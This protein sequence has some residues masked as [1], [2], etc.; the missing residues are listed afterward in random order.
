[1][2]HA[3][4]DFLDDISTAFLSN[5]YG[6]WRQRVRVPLC[7]DLP[8][9]IKIIKSESEA[10]RYFQDCQTAICCQRVDTI[11]CNPI[12]FEE[13]DDGVVLATYETHVFSG[14]L[15]TSKP[16]QSTAMLRKMFGDLVAG[17]ILNAWDFR[18]IPRQ[19]LLRPVRSR[20]TPPC[21]E[22]AELRIH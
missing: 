7:L 16:I 3:F 6:L 22:G 11:I 2:C 9:G 18:T 4:E 5:E 21:G 20:G 17:S 10:R 13:C 8:T 1:M 14:S 19:R 12:A 15:R